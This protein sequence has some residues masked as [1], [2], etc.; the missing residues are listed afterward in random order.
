LLRHY[1]GFRVNKALRKIIKIKK[2][3]IVVIL[4]AFTASQL[5]MVDMPATDAQTAPVSSTVTFADGSLII[6]MDTTYQ[7]MGMWKA[8]GLVYELLSKGI[9]VHWAINDT[10]SFDG[11]D[12][13]A[14]AIDVKLYNNISNHGYSG[15]P[16]IIDSADA[17]KAIPIIELWWAR[18]NNQPIVHQAT[19]SFSANVDI[20]LRSPPRIANEE[21]NAGIAINYYNVAGIP[22]LNGKPWTKDSP[23]ILSQVEIANG[24]LF[25]RGACSQRNFDVFV[26]PH[27]GGYSYSLTDSANLG[28]RTYAEL[29]YF[30]HQGGGWIALCHSILS[31]ENAIAN[32]YNNGSPAVK[33]LFK[34]TGG[35]GFLTKTGFPSIANKG[36]TWTVTEPT[37]PIAQAVLTNGLQGI[38]GGSVKTWDRDVVSYH[39]ETELVAHFADGAKIYDWAINGVAHDGTTLGKV[40]FLGGHTFSTSLPYS[41]NSQAPYLRFFYN[42]LFFNGAAVAKLDLITS[43]EAV[44]QGRES[45][46]NI[47]L[48]NTGSSTATNTNNV[49]IELAPGVEYVETLIG[50]GPTVNGQ[51][52]SWGSSLGDVGGNTTA[53]VIAVKLTPSLV[54][55]IKI[56]N[57]TAKY[58]D[59]YN[60]SFSADLCRSIDVYPAPVPAIEKTPASQTLYQGQIATW[61][62]SYSNTGE[63]AL[64]NA[65]V[66]D[67]L[68]EGFSFKSSDPAPLSVIPLDNGTTRVRWNVGN[69][70]LNDSGTISL[71]SY[72]S[73]VIGEHTNNVKLCGKDTSN[74]YYEVYAEAEVTITPP[75]IELVKSVSPTGQIDVSTPGRVLTYTIR[76][77]Y[78]G[79]RLLENV[80]VSD[81]I[82]AYTSYIPSSANAGG[83]YGF[84][85]LPKVD[86]VD[87]DELFTGTIKTTTNSI[88]VSPTVLA[89]GSTVTVTMTLT[90]NSGGSIS[91]I[92]P[93]ISERLGGAERLTGPSLTGF[94]LANGA[95]QSIS[96]TFEMTEI[97]ERVFE[98]G[99]DGTSS[100]TAI[101]DYSFAGA[102]SN[103]VLV[104]SHLNSSPLNDLVTWRLGSN[105]A[106]IPGEYFESGYPAGIYGLAG[107]NKKISPSTG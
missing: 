66:E 75:A 80:L 13:T 61:E 47:R 3:L 107:A 39:G 11:I 53:V 57:F 92:V 40:T 26:T 46:V 24:G 69:L 98:G 64:L 102:S 63:S 87:N 25:T 16:F 6:P 67:I 21:T 81:P 55:N 20:I 48:E 88:T 27:N 62:L 76:P 79:D 101:G 73:S 33:A 51:T 78:Y 106:R 65:V 28:T 103:T 49:T 41:G 56:A 12:F 96:F 104:T 23:N 77:A 105:T 34:A 42:A 72:V 7:N 35:G 32:L 97:G 29:D 30:V 84:T 83:I 71:S 45:V 89:E 99:A 86:G 9:P 68:P 15:G 22:D 74:Y 8:Y 18:H 52:L 44:P 43:P 50:P 36:G 100:I 38:P 95:T 1:G 2:H 85:P 58:G 14:S 90:N 31:N 70:E 91:N 59:V 19:A 93:F 37:L 54:G 82:P 10:K 60:E 94:N 4:V 17:A 5:S